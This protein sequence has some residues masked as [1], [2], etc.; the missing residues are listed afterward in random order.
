MKGKLRLLTV[1][2]ARHNSEILHQNHSKAQETFFLLPTLIC[3][4]PTESLSLHKKVRLF[5]EHSSTPVIPFIFSILI[6]HCLLFLLFP[7][8]LP[9][10]IFFLYPKYMPIYVGFCLLIISASQISF[11]P[12][13]IFSSAFPCTL[14]NHL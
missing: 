1:N 14:N 10:I 6:I 12:R 4:V 13:L 5:Q 3:L 7:S 11:G 2:H 9:S 8:V